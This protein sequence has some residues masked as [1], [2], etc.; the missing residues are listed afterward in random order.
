MTAAERG[1]AI[2]RALVARGTLGSDPDLL[3]DVLALCRHAERE[4]PA[5]TSPTAGLTPI[6]WE[7]AGGP[8]P[9]TLD[10]MRQADGTDLWAVHRGE[11]V[12]SRDGVWLH[13]PPPAARGDRYRSWCRFATAAE[14][15]AAW[16]RLA[17]GRAA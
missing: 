14:A 3:L 8:F 17:C 12:L 11:S 16:R 1:A 15:L 4:D 10:R 5:V 6:S 13:N 9:A 2:L 7:L